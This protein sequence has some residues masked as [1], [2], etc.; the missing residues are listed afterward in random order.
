MDS[1]DIF[2]L[3]KNDLI[4][5]EKILK[6][7]TIANE[8]ICTDISKHIILKPGKRFRPILLLLTFLSF[9][10]KSN[11]NILK[12]AAAV[13]LLHSASLIH[14][15]IVD[16]STMRRGQKTSNVIWG[17]HASVLAGDFLLSKSLW[18]INQTKN[19]HVMNSVTNA[20]SE[21]ADGQI[22]DLAFSK[23]FN[24]FSIKSYFKMISLKTASLLSSCSE[25]GAILAEANPQK[26]KSMKNFGL[27]LGISFQIVDDMLDFTGDTKILGKRTLQDL[28][29]GKV[30]LPLI[31]AVN[32]TSKNNFK[33]TESIIKQRKFDRKS[34]DFLY[35]LIINED[36]LNKTKKEAERFA[37]KALT[38]IKVLDSSIYKTALE[39]LLKGNLTRIT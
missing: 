12:A 27:N 16:D 30:T 11:S 20:A 21:L 29:D 17:D 6:D 28:K 8:T 1:K 39:F 26:V 23:K 24:D 2:N 5:V 38:N 34:L 7:S 3:L 33:K 13:E 37:K 19:N 4:K 18:L 36:S 15:D 9:K 32:S 31:M 10:K 35:N 14:D 22:M 25:V